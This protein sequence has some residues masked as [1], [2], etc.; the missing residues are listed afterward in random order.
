MTRKILFVDDEKNVLSALRRQLRGKFD[1]TVAEGGA[2]G[3][4]AI[5]T[6]GPFAVVVT[7]MRMPSMNG[8]EFLRE[9]EKKAP[10]TVRMMLTGNADQ[11]TAVRA[12]N[13]GKVF[14]FFSKPCTTEDLEVGLNAG[15]KQH[16][17]ITAEH[18]LLQ[19]TLSGSIKV[20][21]DIVR[22]SDSTLVGNPVRLRDLA[23]AV[24]LELKVP[25]VWR[26]ELAAVK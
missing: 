8:I 21:L 22:L 17:L 18:E 12:V 24:A 26:I 25:M 19:Q 11:E 1:V 9:V 3:L 6:E 15:I 14:R 16:D 20:L 5:E 4:K 7:D 13:Q 10:D 23:R 2:A